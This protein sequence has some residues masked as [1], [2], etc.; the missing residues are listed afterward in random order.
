MC[1][2]LNEYQRL[3]EVTSGARGLVYNEEVKAGDKRLLTAALGLLGEVVELYAL[4][5]EE[6]R[7]KEAGDVAWYIAES[8]STMGLSLEEL[9]MPFSHD[10]PVPISGLLVEA[11]Q[12]GEYVKKVVFHGHPFDRMKMEHLLGN[13]LAYL[14]DYCEEK[15]LRLLEVLDANIEKLK[16]R[17]NDKFTTA[18]SLNR[19]E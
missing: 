16:K 12:F 18:A 3:A 11:G 17:Y 13:V 1:G 2:K 14:I 7:V 10:H 8:C 15:K 5:K 9:P 4:K 19:A 6:H